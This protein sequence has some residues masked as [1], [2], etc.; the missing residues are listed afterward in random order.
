MRF[1]VAMSKKRCNFARMKQ[2]CQF[3]LHASIASLFALITCQC[4]REKTDM[5]TVQ[6]VVSVVTNAS[7]NLWVATDNGL[8]RADSLG[9]LHQQPLPSLT[10]HPFPSIHALA[11][12]TIGHRLWIGAW[13]HLYCYDLQRERFIT[14]PDSAIHQTTALQIDTLGRVIAKTGHGL[15]RYTLNDTLPNGMTEQ[16]NGIAY[17]KEPNV[18]VCIDG[19]HFPETDSRPLF[20][21]WLI[22][23]ACLACVVVDFYLRKKRR[24]A[25][26]DDKVTAPALVQPTIN[27]PN[28]DASYS[29][30]PT[31]LERAEQIVDIHI[32]D[33]SFNADV[34]AQ[35]MAVSRA[36]LF[37]K[38]KASN[39]QTVMEFINER[40][41]ALAD[42]L[43]KTTDRTIAD[44]ASAT[45]FSE[46]SNF[47]RAFLKWSGKNPS[48]VRK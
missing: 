14:T 9:E 6:A 24:P 25:E 39:G 34:F 15:Y 46:A 42:H 35:E 7:S 23:A 16:L 19:C 4:S 26:A 45:G 27:A 22:L 36:Q 32:A 37:R 30:R 1:F 3:F 29:H 12:D 13:N 2:R 20:Y 38:L 43:L 47:R 28:S 17:Q 31:F 33:Q 41:M 21:I 48:E 11:L 40:R 44:I 10:H 18:A 5:P 8:Y